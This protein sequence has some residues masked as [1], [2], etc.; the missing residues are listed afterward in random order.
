VTC[1][2]HIGAEP[3]RRTQGQPASRTW[4]LTPSSRDLP[5]GITKES[6]R[7][8][9]KD[10]ADAWHTPCSNVRLEVSAPADRW[11]AERDGANLLVFREQ[12]WCHNAQCGH[13]GTFPLRAMAMTTV[14]R[15]GARGVRVEEADAGVARRRMLQRS[16]QIRKRKHLAA[17]DEHASS[18]RRREERQL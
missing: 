16:R 15:D 17:A 5:S 4:V 1:A 11:L 9:L 13:T 12:A 6:W 18:A 8:V 7:T 14:Y 3:A 2:R 10:A